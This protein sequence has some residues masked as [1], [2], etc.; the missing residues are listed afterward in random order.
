MPSEFAAKVT[1]F[2][3]SSGPTDLVGTF[4]I[5]GVPV[6]GRWTLTRCTRHWKW[7]Y[8]VVPGFGALYTSVTQPP[9]E[10]EFRGVF[11]SPIDWAAFKVL[12]AKFLSRPMVGIIPAP[13]LPGFS[14]GID[15][16]ELA[17]MN[18]SAVVLE[19]KY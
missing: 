8:Q 14:I 18:I 7:A 12:E 13:L 17:R 5:V 9:A 11:A 6:P 16:H 15:H 10:I 2:P 1:S 4:R 19:E 3:I